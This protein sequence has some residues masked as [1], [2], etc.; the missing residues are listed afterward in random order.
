MRRATVVLMVA[1]LG[2]CVRDLP[3]SELGEHALAIF[4]DFDNAP[5]ELPASVEA[6]DAALDG[7]D[8]EGSRRHRMF[9]LP[10]LTSAEYAGLTV[11]AGIDTSDQMRASMVALSPHS[12]D[13]LLAVLTEVN[14][15]CINA[16][17]VK[18]HERVPAAG[19]VAADFI[20]GTAEVFRS[21]NTIRI[22]SV[23]DIWL[24]A[25]LDRVQPAPDPELD[26][27]FVSDFDRMDEAA[28]VAASA[29]A[30]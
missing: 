5:A 6:L 2:G 7:L 20:A 15:S 29:R 1:C 27:D 10:E 14:Q 18:C 22:E 28:C 30:G 19:S 12:L 21:I 25:P 17:A 13:E 16:G 3:E 11:A 24:Q 4:R 9:D 26:G 23:K 8:L